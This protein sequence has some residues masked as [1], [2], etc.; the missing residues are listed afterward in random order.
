VNTDNEPGKAM[1]LFTTLKNRRCDGFILA[2]AFRHDPVVEAIVEQNIPA[3]LVNRLTEKNLLPAVVGDEHKEVC[4]AIAHLVQLGHRRIA[5]IAGPQNLSTGYLRRRAFH[6]AI[7][8]TGLNVEECPVVV[9]TGFYESAGWSAT[10][11]LISKKGEMPTAILAANDQLALGVIDALEEGGIICPTDV[12]V[13]GFND[14]PMMHRIKPA[15]TTFTL[16]K[17]QMGLV[18]AQTLQKWIE[19]SIKPEPTTI[20]LPCPLVVRNSTAPVAS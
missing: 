17:H 4:D 6:C 16:P 2:T 9:A 12:S 10:N 18:A 1:Q 20:Y 8:D 13:I 5:H 15:L 7:K 19:E 14:I 3:V 11:H